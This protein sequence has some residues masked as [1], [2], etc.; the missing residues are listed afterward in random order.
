MFGITLVWNEQPDPSDSEQAKQ[1]THNI[2]IEF[3]YCVYL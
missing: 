2:G 1:K 3:Q